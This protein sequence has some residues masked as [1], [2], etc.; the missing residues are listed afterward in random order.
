MATLTDTNLALA[1]VKLIAS[2][3]VQPLVGN[4]VMGNLVNR[5]YEATLANAGDTVNVPIPPVMTANN[6]AETG[7][8]Q[9]QNPSPGNAQIV[10]N[11][12]IES[13]FVV[14]DVA[15]AMVA[16]L[17]DPGAP[18]LYMQPAQVALAEKIEADL[19]ALYPLF[20]YNTPV[21]ASATP[22]SESVIDL[23]DT[24]MFNA[25]VP[26]SE[27]KSLI[28]S[29]TAYGA[30]RQLD[31]FTEAQTVG[32]GSAITT[33]VLGTIKNFDVYRSQFV[34]KPS[35]TTFNFA[36]ARNAIALAIRKLPLPLP[37]TGAVAAYAE[38][39]GFVFRVVMSYNPNSLAQQF[40]VDCLYGTGVLRNQFG[41][42]VQS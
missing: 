14:P 27:K 11:S 5:D 4:L 26:T 6:I 38:F 29:A 9:T 3:F 40:T 33:G 41:Q 37:G 13:S 10:L 32:T 21:G 30:V 17:Q 24:Q 22:I 25:K 31:R 15:K 36:F 12:H 19:L 39:G 34:P 8:V 42:V 35:A 16:I 2:Q 7:T 28:L 20:T 1:I 23:A 18:Q